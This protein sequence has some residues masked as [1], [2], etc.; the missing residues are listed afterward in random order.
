MAMRESRADDLDRTLRLL[1]SDPANVQEFRRFNSELNEQTS[2]L[3]STGEPDDTESP[4]KDSDFLVRL[5][6]ACLTED[7][8]RNFAEDDYIKRDFVASTVEP[9]IASW[10]AAQNLRSAEAF[11]EMWQYLLSFASH[12]RQLPRYRG[13]LDHDVI[14]GVK[15]LVAADGGTITGVPDFDHNVDTD[16]PIRRMFPDLDATL[17]DPTTCDPV[18]GWYVER[19][20]DQRRQ[21]ASAGKDLTT[22]CVVEKPFSVVG[23][24]TLTAAL[25][26]Q[27]G[28]PA[29][30]Y[31]LG[32]W[33]RGA[34]VSGTQ[35]EPGGTAVIVYDT[36]IAGT[37]LHEAALFL[38]EEYEVDT[39]AAIVLYDFNA[40]GAEALADSGITLVSRL[41]RTRVQREI[42]VRERTALTELAQGEAVIQMKETERA[43]S[44]HPVSEDNASRL[45]AALR[46]EF[47]PEIEQSNQNL[48][49]DGKKVE[50]KAI[51]S[52]ALDR[53]RAALRE[54]FRPEIEQFNAD[55]L[56]QRN[57][58]GDIT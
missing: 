11:A 30:I 10:G 17:T 15:F 46:E 12:Y 40:G 16:D 26:Q 51:D 14:D 35:P 31:R 48:H 7:V 57:P 28:L 49:G 4:E 20:E 41:D 58:D 38:H 52:V 13:G 55:E 22:L 1:R 37:A 43:A 2:E 23:G 50:S 56:H 24:L 5:L 33:D 8:L 21:L 6:Y 44:Q 29:V 18:L 32:Y 36:A 42:Q 3:Q 47:R 27:V 19:I 54:E 39:A 9:L 53:L 34:R 45:R 25:V